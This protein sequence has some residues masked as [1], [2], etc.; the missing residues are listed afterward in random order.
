MKLRC[1]NCGETKHTLYGEKTM[2]GPDAYACL[3]A[4]CVKCKSI[5]HIEVSMPRIHFE[6]HPKAKG[7]LAAF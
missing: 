6:W 3:K 7:I 1:G 2:G 5:T 4:K